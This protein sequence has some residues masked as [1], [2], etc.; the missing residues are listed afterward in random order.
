[1]VD[2]G[3]RATTLVDGQR[4]VVGQHRLLFNV[5]RPSTSLGRWSVSNP[6]TTISQH[7]LV[8]PLVNIGRGWS[9]LVGRSVYVS[10]TSVSNFVN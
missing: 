7:Q 3:C 6:M 4:L 1:M 8:S 2:L 10:A 9:T 5:G